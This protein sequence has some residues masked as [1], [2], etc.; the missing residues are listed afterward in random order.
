LTAKVN[1]CSIFCALYKAPFRLLVLLCIPLAANAVVATKQ[2]GR[3]VV[4]ALEGSD[5]V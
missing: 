5:E 4:A 1:P 2:G 3:G